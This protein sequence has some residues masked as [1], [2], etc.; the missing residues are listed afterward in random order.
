VREAVEL[1]FKSTAASEKLSKMKYQSQGDEGAGLRLT[2]IEALGRLRMVER[3]R[4]DG[5]RS[6]WVDVAADSP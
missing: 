2:D 6:D 4:R 3:S 1:N 5:S